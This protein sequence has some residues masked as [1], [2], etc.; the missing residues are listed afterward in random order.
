MTLS[1]DYH[2]LNQF[3]QRNARDQL[4]RACRYIDRF[5]LRL[6]KTQNYWMTLSELDIKLREFVPDYEKRFGKYQLLQWLN[7]F[8]WY[9]EIDMDGQRMRQNPKYVRY[10]LL[11]QAYWKT[12]SRLPFYSDF[13]S[14]AQFGEVLREL[15]RDYE[16]EFGNR[17]LSTWLKEYPDKF[18]ISEGS[19][20]ILPYRPPLFS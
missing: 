18:K 13:V 10:S 16:S 2:Y 9:L 5:C 11:V 15:S 8:D 14:L 3:Y 20:T 17:K 7:N 4:N 1:F 12:R 6:Y 19:V